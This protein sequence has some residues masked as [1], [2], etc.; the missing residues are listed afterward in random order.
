MKKCKFLLLRL[1]LLCNYN[2]SHGKG[3]EL[4][5]VTFECVTFEF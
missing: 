5:C 3:I 4:S 1:K 2:A